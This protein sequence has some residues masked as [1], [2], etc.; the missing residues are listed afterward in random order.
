MV[1]VLLTINSLL[2]IVLPVLLG[3]WL[4][5]RYKVGWKLFFIGAAGFVVSQI[6]HIPFNQYV[7]KPFVDGFMDQGETIGRILIAAL[8]FGL[9]AGVF[10]EV[11]RYVFYYFRKSMRRWDEGLMFGAGWGGVEAILLG[12]LAATTVINVYIYQSGLIETLVPGEQ[13]A[14]SSEA[15]AAAAQEIEELVNSPPWLFLLGAVERVITLVLHLSLSILVL[16]AFVRRNI[17]WLFAAIGWH[18][19]IDAIAVVGLYQEWDPLL[20]EAAI[21]IPA[22]IIGLFIIRYFK[23]QNETPLNQGD[24][25]DGDGA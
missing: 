23:P 25:L 18:T 15:I 2:M 8:L 11:T 10:E 12:L 22:V 1:Y 13:L 5:R 14:G 6:G 24:A 7:L 20:I 9:S 17:I 19:L 3:I 4:A 21:G 16:Q